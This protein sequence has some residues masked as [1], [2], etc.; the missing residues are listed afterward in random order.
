[1]YYNVLSV[2][3]FLL[4]LLLCGVS[5]IPSLAQQPL[6]SVRSVANTHA[7]DDKT[8]S[9]DQVLEK[10]KAQHQVTFGYQEDLVAGKTVE[11]QRWKKQELKQALETVLKPHGLEFKQLDEVHFVI[12]PKENKLPKKILPKEVGA[13]DNQHV[14][15]KVS[16]LTSLDPLSVQEHMRLA[17]T[18][19]GQVTDGESGEPLPGVNILAKGTTKGTIT[20][21]GGNYRLT[22][23][24]D[25]KLLVFSSIGYLSEEV[26]ING[27]STINLSLMPDIQS[28]SEVVVIGYGAQR[29]KDLTGAV[30][31]VNEEVIQERP[32]TSVVQSLQGAVA[33]LN[34]GQVNAAGEEPTLSIRG[35]TSIS[36][37]QDPLIVLDGAIFRGKL[38]D[39]NPNDIQSIDVLKDASSTAIYGS[40]AANGVIII[41]TKKG[42]GREGL[43]VNFSMYY[44]LMEPTKKFIPESP[45]QL[46]D[47]VTSAYFMDSRTA[48]SGYLDPNPD[49]D[50]TSTSRTTD[51]ARAYAENIVTDWYGITTNKNLNAQNYDFSIANRNSQGGYYLSAGYTQQDGYMVNEDYNRFNTRINIDHDLTDWLEIGVQSFLTSS[52]Y[53]GQE[54]PPS[55][56]YL[57]MLYAPAYEAD[58]VTLLQNPRGV[59]TNIYNPLLLMQ[60]EDLDK[61]LNLFGS[62]YADF[63]IPFIQG[64]SFK[65]RFN[66]NSI[67]NSQYYYQ[68]YA[69]NFLA[70]GQKYEEIGDNWVN[71]N[72]LT[73]NRIFNNKHNINATIAYGREKR[74]FNATTATASNFISDALGYNRLQA[75]SADLQSVETFAWEE[76][77]LYQLN[78][79]FYGYDDRYLLTFTVRT[80]GFSGFGEDYKYGTFPSA[81]FAW[82]L[83]EESFFKDRFEFIDNLKIRGSYGANGNRTVGR[84]ATLSRVA[85]GFDY[86]N[87]DDVPVYTQGNA[88]LANPDLKW[89]TT[90][91]YNIGLDFS[92][93][94]AKVSGSIN[95]Y[96]TNT[97]DL[98][99]DVDIPGITRFETIADNLGKLHN[100]GME[101]NVSTQN[102]NKSNFRWSTDLNFSYN[103]NELRELLGFDNDGDGEEDDLISEGLFIGESLDAIYALETDGEIWQIDEE[104]PNTADIGSYKITDTNGDGQITLD[105]RVILGNALPA[106]RWSMNNRFTYRN[107]SLSVF[108][109]SA[110]GNDN[111]YLGRDALVGTGFNGLNDMLWDNTTFPQG[112]DFWLPE[113]PNARYQRLGVSVPNALNAARYIDRS[114]VRL[115]NVTL[116]YSLGQNVLDKLF[117][118]ENIR[119]FV[120]G[121]N[122]QTWTKWPGWDPETGEGITIGGRPVLRYYTFGLDVR[123]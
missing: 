123:F 59:G 3:K 110:M 30:S 52:D 114:F 115:Q 99:Y 79:L 50:V 111:Y 51:I 28:L 100:E 7:Q 1:M 4:F 62:A 66:V 104:I 12:T 75:G 93:F 67:R 65:S 9:L 49:F 85:G 56:R 8:M 10:I 80:D 107:W 89:E 35:R 112:L 11:T 98:L 63:K 70:E 121:R 46:K 40:Q 83:S 101:V 72:I 109:N 77:N 97:E 68:P 16:M 27:R 119:L 32:A 117:D 34:V 42:A 116:S 106:F 118:I 24:D 13:D 5:V 41:T 92:L 105:D 87:G 17:Q 91:G 6:A 81:S 86:I 48:A 45:N 55:N 60:S 37:S 23:N 58:G 108:I 57:Y 36:G 2:A 44:S 31:S 64:L 76:T 122:L 78:R 18:I 84:Y 90:I 120:S 14:P 43:T 53:S 103:R 25:V 95:Y 113:N 94:N 61:R 69:N 71:D 88:T 47:R 82:V 15:N 38:I 19:S 74:R 26:E 29:K 96:N 54:V 21:G 22:V 33:G 73:Y 102:I 20:D 39:I